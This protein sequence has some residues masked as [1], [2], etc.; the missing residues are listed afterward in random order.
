MVLQQQ[1]TE[2]NHAPCAQINPHFLFNSLNTTPS[3]RPDATRREATTPAWP[4]L[5]PCAG[6]S[7]RPPTSIRDEIAFRPICTRRGGRRPPEGGDRDGPETAGEEIPWI[8]QPLVENAQ[9]RTGAAT[10]PGRLWISACAGATRFAA[11][12]GR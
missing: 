12:G 11:R 5:P 4:C 10:G 1:V 9:A 2:A 8:L 7:S 3:R 6:Q